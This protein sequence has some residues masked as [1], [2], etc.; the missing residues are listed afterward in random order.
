MKT[1]KRNFSTEKKIIQLR[2]KCLNE[3]FQLLLFS[4]E[5]KSLTK[6]REVTFFF[7]YT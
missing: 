7:V 4:S 3:N 6:A 1:A 2:K 5:A